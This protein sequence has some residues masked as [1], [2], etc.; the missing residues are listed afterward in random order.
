MAPKI[1]LLK[2][3]ADASLLEHECAAQEFIVATDAVFFKAQALA[4]GWQMSWEHAISAIEQI[5]LMHFEK[6]VIKLEPTAPVVAPKTVMDLAPTPA[7]A[8]LLIQCT[9]SVPYIADPS[10]PPMHLHLKLL[11]QEQ[12]EVHAIVIIALLTI[13]LINVG[14][15]LASALAG[16]VVTNPKAVCGM[17]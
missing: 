7:S 17:A 5:R 13:W 10:S 2:V 16:A 1:L 14:T 3:S 6:M 11:L 9:P 15:R 4:N 8:T 12:E